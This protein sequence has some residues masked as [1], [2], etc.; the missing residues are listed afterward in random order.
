MTSLKVVL[1][2]VVIIAS[3][4]VSG[5]KLSGYVLDGET[6]EPVQFANVF[7]ANTLVGTTT[8]T[9][10]YFEMKDFSVGKY[11]LVISFVGYTTLVQSIE[12][13]EYEVKQLH[14]E[15][16][17]DQIQLSDIWVKEDTSGWKENFKIFKENF[18]GR[19]ENAEKA[20]ILNPKTLH[21]YFDKKTRVLYAHAREPIEV[22]NDALGYK[23]SY[24]L[25]EFEIDF[26]KGRFY[27]FGIPHFSEL[28]TDSK[29]RRKKWGKARLEA[30]NGSTVHF[31]RS[32]RSATLNEE[33]FEVNKVFRVPNPDKLPIDS[34]NQQIAY[35]KALAIA[36]KMM[37]METSQSMNY[38]N[39][40][41][42]K[43]DLVDS[44]GQRIVTGNEI[45]SNQTDVV[46]YQGSLRV[47]YL[48]E[49]EAK[50]YARLHHRA[51]PL[52]VQISTIDFQEPLLKIYEN[53][54]YEDVKSTFIDGYWAWSSNMAE[55][56]PLEYIP[57][58]K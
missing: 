43:P 5:Q 36:Q 37:D 2:L 56:L 15:M 13:Q 6:H 50:G 34:I 54:Y 7:F 41:K 17:P 33:G 23:L 45:K 3:Q 1:Y 39:R 10:G 18:L 20:K 35:Y 12:F 52:R 29:R 49:K 26:A 28:E 4:L 57:P 32:L 51:A 58:A 9:K 19:T 47:K 40:M 24:L 11:D 27:S 42:Q 48:N 16:Q 22:Q 14:L 46:G 38:W 31:F 21:L 30:Y 53:G 44:L 55:L 25:Y 8:D